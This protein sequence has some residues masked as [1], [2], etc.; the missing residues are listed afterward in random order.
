[1]STSMQQQVSCNATSFPVTF[2]VTLKT[3]ELK[4]KE[5]GAWIKEHREKANISQETAAEKVGL[6][7]FQWIRIE[8]G[9]SGTKRE[10]LID[11]ANAIFADVEKTLLK[12]GYAPDEIEKVEVPKRI[13]DALAR[14][15]KLFPEDEIMIAGLIEK[16]KKANS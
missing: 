16:M 6:S 14:E 15:G 1:M 12:G 5:L 8:N 3:K 13:L 7:R 10:T 2:L 9:Q 4:R 11:I